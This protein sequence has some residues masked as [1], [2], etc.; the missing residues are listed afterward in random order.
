MPLVFSDQYDF[1]SGVNIATDLT[2][3]RKYHRMNWP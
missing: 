3:I 2:L 1:H